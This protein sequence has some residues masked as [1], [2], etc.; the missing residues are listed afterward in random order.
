MRIPIT[1]LVV[2][3]PFPPFFWLSNLSVAPSAI[4][5]RVS[6]AERGRH[7]SC[8]HRFFLKNVTSSSLNCTSDSCYFAS[9]SPCTHRCVTGNRTPP[10]QGPQLSYLT[11]IRLLPD[12]CLPGILAHPPLLGAIWLLAGPPSSTHYTFAVNVAAFF[13]YPLI[14]WGSHP[15][16]RRSPVQW[17]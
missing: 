3:Y 15:R 1:L 11:P 6:G 12:Q 14:W 8:P 5:R 10:I 9:P 13:H 4:R 2:T 16:P 17:T 7:R